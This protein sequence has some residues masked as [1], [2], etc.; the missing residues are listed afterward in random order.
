MSNS[1]SNYF[2]ALVFSLFIFLSINIPAQIPQFT[3]RTD[4]GDVDIPGSV[5]FK[6]DT[7]IM[8]GSGNN[9]WGDNDAFSFLWNEIKGDISLSANVIWVDKGKNPHRKAGWM[10]R[11]G[12]EKDDPYVDAV[13]HGDGLISMQYR[14]IKGD[15][16]YEVQLPLKM[17]GILILEKTGDQFT[18]T[19]EDQEGKQHIVGTISMEMK[20]AY[21]AG[22]AICSHDSTVSETAKFSNIKFHE[23]DSLSSG[24][25]IVESTLEILNIASGLRTTI[26]KAKEHFEAPNW[27]RD[28]NYFLYNSKGKIYKLPITGGEPELL[29]T[30]FA[31]QCNNDHGISPD[32]KHLVVSHHAEDGK[33]MIYVLPIRGGEPR[34]VTKLGPSYWHGWSPDGKTL[35]YCAERNGEYDIYTISVS[36]GNETRLTSAPGLDDGPDYSPDGN[37]IYFNSVRTGQMKIWRMKTDG[38]EQTQITPDDNFGDWFAHPS[39]DGKWLVFLSYDKSV[40]GHPA[41][42]DVLL[43]IMPVDGGEI[44]IAATLF[45]GQGTI[46][47]PSWSPDNKHV[48]F[49]SYRLMK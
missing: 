2:R 14:K 37:F 23:L 5:Q 26:R 13:V 36:G 18:L 41:N 6:Q 46:N 34:L 15:L 3:G 43:R 11:S 30:S 48:A 16:T 1:N 33:S 39:S 4:I 47:V 32:G 12:L 20:E 38:T 40:E 42:K 24:E 35:A 8:T 19:I 45:G 25:R 29:N 22:L 49:V 31:V 10:I 9:I 44:K 7:I 28:G 17:K 21:Y 27:S